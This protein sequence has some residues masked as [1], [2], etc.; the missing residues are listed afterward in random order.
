MTLIEKAQHQCNIATELRVLKKI[1]NLDDDIMIEQTV[2]ELYTAIE[3]E[4]FVSIMEKTAEL[5]L[6]L[7]T[8]SKRG[9]K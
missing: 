5:S 7:K 3:Q 9:I 4:H 6:L 8:L 2:G 1:K